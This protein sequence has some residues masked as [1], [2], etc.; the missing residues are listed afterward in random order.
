MIRNRNILVRTHFLEFECRLMLQS[1]QRSKVAIG[2]S[3]I[4]SPVK[5][6]GRDFYENLRHHS[7]STVNPANQCLPKRKEKTK[8]EAFGCVSGRWVPTAIKRKEHSGVARRSSGAATGRETG[9]RCKLA[10]QSIGSSSVSRSPV[11]F[12]FPVEPEMICLSSH[13]EVLHRPLA[14]S[15]P[16]LCQNSPVAS[17]KM[18]KFT[19]L[20]KQTRN[21]SQEDH[22][23]PSRRQILQTSFGSG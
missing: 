23:A 11:L 16:G 20:A 10:S 3:M 13:N 17:F 8:G 15:M 21:T 19:S 2:Q 7:A 6:L 9:N 5:N 18:H 14:T 22:F 4:Q 12:V 1:M